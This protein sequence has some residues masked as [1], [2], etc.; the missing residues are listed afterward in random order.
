MGQNKLLV[1]FFEEPNRLFQIRE[2]ARLAKMP[3]STAARMLKELTKERLIA[4][5]KENVVGYIANETDSYFRLLK[6]I[7]FLKTVHQSGLIDYLSDNFHPEC[8][9]LFGSFAK[10]E[11][12][13]GSDID[14]FLQSKEKSYDLAKF[15]KKLKHAVNLFFEEN[16]SNLSNE[17]FNNIINGIKLSGYIRLK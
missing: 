9:I 12:N 16:F 6:K 5:R 14:I 8:I 10:G 13:K 15:E 7:S 1:L 2:I 4:R 17:L 3:K 11:Y